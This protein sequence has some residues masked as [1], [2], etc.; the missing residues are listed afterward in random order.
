MLGVTTGGAFEGDETVVSKIAAFEVVRF[1]F[2]LE[3]G[4]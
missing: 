1:V 4:F 2:F 3:L